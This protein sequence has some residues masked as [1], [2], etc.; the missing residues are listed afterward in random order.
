MKTFETL[1]SSSD[2]TRRLWKFGMLDARF[3]ML[4]VH[5]VRPSNRLRIKFCLEAANT[6]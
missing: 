2:P 1:A 4:G 5:L 6:P 3:S